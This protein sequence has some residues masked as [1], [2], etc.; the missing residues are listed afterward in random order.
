[1]NLTTKEFISIGTWF[2]I[3]N[4]PNCSTKLKRRSP[5]MWA[6]AQ[7]KKL[8]ARRIVTSRPKCFAKMITLISAQSALMTCITAR[9]ITTF[10]ATTR[11]WRSQRSPNSSASVRSMESRTSSFVIAAVMPIAASASYQKC[12]NQGLVKSTTTWSRWKTPILQR[13]LVPIA[14]MML[15]RRRKK[16]SKNGSR[17]SQRRWGSSRITQFRSK[18]MSIRC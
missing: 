17:L 6:R 11:K 9:L 13:S 4:G 14:T 10:L 1:M 8:C 7:T 5:L 3:H 16:L 15:L 18:K 12:K 2:T